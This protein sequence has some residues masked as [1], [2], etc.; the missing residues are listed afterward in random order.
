M[1]GL[2][3]NSYCSADILTYQ[4][5]PR[6]WAFDRIPG[7]QLF[8]YDD[9]PLSNVES[10]DICLEKCSIEDSFVCRSARYD[11]FNK[12]CVLSRHDRRTAPEAFRRSLRQV[13]YLENQCVS[14]ELCI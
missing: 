6:Q 3:C 13:E 7:V 14:G 9:K 1:S 4:P 2:G 5:C 10:R 11:R 8:G 12:T